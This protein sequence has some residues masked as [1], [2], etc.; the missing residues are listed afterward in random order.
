MPNVSE[1]AVSPAGSRDLPCPVRADPVAVHGFLTAAC[2]AERQRLVAEH[3]SVLG[4][5]DGAPPA[6]RYAANDLLMHAAG[7]PY[8]DRDGRYLLF[9]PRGRGRIARVFGDLAAAD[10]ITVLV[11]G[12]GNRVVN[13]WNGV[14]GEGY[15][16]P[17][18]QAA[19]L[20]EAACRR[21]GNP[22]RLAVIAWL[23]YD[24][25]NGNDLAVARQ[26][27]AQAGAL[28][29]RRFLAGLVVVCPRASIALFGHSYGS[30][31]IGLAASGLPARVSDVAVFGSPGM[32][33]DNAAQLG[34]DARL[35]AG[36]STRD[37]IRW[38]PRSRLFGFGH[39]TKPADPRFGARVFP[40]SDVADHD[41]YLSPGTDSL[42][43]LARIAAGRP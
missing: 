19:V 40:T 27:R 13:F 24:T 9:D 1:L 39:G 22:G 25:P 42:S 3:P 11:P 18:A 10:R 37:W 38:V 41:H 4:A 36:Q 8:R 31:V 43:S 12:A 17:S 34:I 30:T 6:L 32:G 21:A 33:V 7:P 28:A 29:L 15:R 35:W 16:S 23:G 20:Y 14:G 5:L 26:E 2:A